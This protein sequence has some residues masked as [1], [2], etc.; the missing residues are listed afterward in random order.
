MP[1]RAADARVS[2]LTCLAA[3]D[4]GSGH[5]VGLEAKVR[6]HPAGLIRE[7]V[8]CGVHDGR[9]RVERGQ[10]ADGCAGWGGYVL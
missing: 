3:T 7:H 9:V 5:G 1:T 4:A 8:W 2:T 6:S 10:L